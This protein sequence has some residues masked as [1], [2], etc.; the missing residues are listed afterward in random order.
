[1]S[2]KK[3]TIL[4][5]RDI[6]NDLIDGERIIRMARVHWAIFL[7]PAITATIALAVGLLL[8]WVISITIFIAIVLVPL[9]RST[10]LYLTTQLVVTNK[11]ILSRYGFFSRDLI[12]IRM[13]RLETAYLEEPFL[14][15][16][17]GYSTVV[18]SGT[19]SGGLSLPFITKGDVLVKSLQTFI[20][21]R[22]GDK[23]DI[24]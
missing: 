12:Q 3:P 5:K 8:S 4:K 17:F 9:V 22:G 18:L 6:K 10:I 20:L 7:F 16:I 15:Q 1:M 24:K 21:K 2:D 23:E 11:R 19:G 14:G 13:D